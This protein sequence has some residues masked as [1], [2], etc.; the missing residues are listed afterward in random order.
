M[1]RGADRGD[2]VVVRAI[3][4]RRESSERPQDHSETRRESRGGDD[5]SIPTP[6]LVILIFW[7]TVL[8][9]TFGLFSPGNAT[10]LSV[11]FIC[12]LSLAGALFLIVELDRPF[13]GLIQISSRPMHAAINHL[14]H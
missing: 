1:E 3:R 6:F 7:L 8:F 4:R 13:H 14:G 11:L 5:S 10:V 2:R 12:A 9:A